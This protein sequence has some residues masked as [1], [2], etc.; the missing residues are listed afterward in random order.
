MEKITIYL[1]KRL[2]QNEN[3]V[4]LRTPHSTP[5]GSIRADLSVG[6]DSNA[7]GLYKN[8]R[9]CNSYIHICFI[10]VKETIPKHVY[11]RVNRIIPLNP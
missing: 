10:K 2:Y 4:Q 3:T 9:G 6:L 11:S 8:Y 7:N 1:D 5:I